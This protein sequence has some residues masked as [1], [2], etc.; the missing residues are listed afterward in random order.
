V[1]LSVARVIQ[2]VSKNHQDVF[3]DTVRRSVLKEPMGKPS[4]FRRVD[5][6]FFEQIQLRFVPGGVRASGCDAR[7]LALATDQR[8]H[9]AG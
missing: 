6:I 9:R 7:A 8:V 2:I 1:A 3:R 5:A 4:D